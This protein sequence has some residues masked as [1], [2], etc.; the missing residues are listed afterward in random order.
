M[1]YKL[2]LEELEGEFEENYV[3]SSDL[4]NCLFLIVRPVEVLKPTCKLKGIH[5]KNL[6]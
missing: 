2:V 6:H 1:K 5:A 3:N 4:P